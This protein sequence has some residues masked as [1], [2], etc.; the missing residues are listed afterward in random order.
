MAVV[1][2][3]VLVEYLACGEHAGAAGERL[4]TDSHPI[5]A[6]HLIDAEVGHALRRGVRRGVLDEDA[7]GEAL[8]MLDQLPVRRVSHELLVRYAWTLRENVTFYDAL[9]VAL[10]E[11][12]DEPLIT[13]DARLARSGVRAQVEV[14]AQAA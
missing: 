11:M 1:D 8:W 3:S 6:P 7:A 14:L 13:F 2:A 4:L 10:A 9:Y 12:L 5:W